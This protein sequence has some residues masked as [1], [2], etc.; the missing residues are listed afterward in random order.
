MKKNIEITIKKDKG[1]KLLNTIQSFE[2]SE[3]NSVKD[4]INTIKNDVHQLN[5][6][7]IVK[8][9]L[10][11]GTQLMKLEETVPAKNGIELEITVK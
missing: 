5:G 9:E 11:Y 6:M 10:F 3:N 1:G 2:L 8:E 7:E 4:L